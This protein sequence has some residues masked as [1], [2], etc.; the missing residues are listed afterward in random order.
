ML[1]TINVKTINAPLVVP[2]WKQYCFY[3]CSGSSAEGP[4][5][6][7]HLQ[8]LVRG[9][10]VILHLKCRYWS[11]WSDT[12]SAILLQPRAMAWSSTW[13]SARSFG[14]TGLGVQAVSRTN[15]LTSGIQAFKTLWARCTGTEVHVICWHIFFPSGFDSSS[16]RPWAVTRGK[17]ISLI[18]RYLL[19]TVVSCLFALVGAYGPSS[20]VVIG[21][22]GQFQ[23]CVCSSGLFPGFG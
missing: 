13:N 4:C 12:S 1:K 8:V 17:S 20:T 18:T 10:C 21:T 23:P 9:S 3:T 19:R 2:C 14:L 22:S 15:V 16:S 5:G 7:V 6:S 11:R